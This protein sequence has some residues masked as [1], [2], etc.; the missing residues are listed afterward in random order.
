MYIH[1]HLGHADFTKQFKLY[2]DVC[3]WGLGTILYQNQDRIDR[4][5]CYASRTL[6]KTEHKYLAHKLEFL[7]LK[8]AIT[9]QFYEYLYGNTFIVYMDNYLL[10]YVLTSE[11]LDKT[12]HQ[13]VAS[14]TNYNIA[15]RYKSA[16]VNVDAATL[17]HIPLED[18]DQKTKADTVKVLIFKC[19]TVLYNILLDRIIFTN[20]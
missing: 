18:H 8:W 11:K 12:G 7:A 17:S 20:I 3:I 13:W 16:K 15:L 1:S 10:T 5:I 2:T 14:L 6:S 9:E 19:N 4:V